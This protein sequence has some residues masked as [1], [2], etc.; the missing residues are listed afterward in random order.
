MHFIF[1]SYCSSF[2]Y[3]YY[4][5]VP[6]CTVQVYMSVSVCVHV[7]VNACENQRTTLDDILET[8]STLL[9]ETGALIGLKFIK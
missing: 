9:L 4:T 7:C 3:F 2:N 6:M 8:L 5:S 1:S